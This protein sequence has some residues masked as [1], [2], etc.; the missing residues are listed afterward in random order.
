[1]DSR[2]NALKSLHLDFTGGNKIPFVSGSDKIIYHSLDFVDIVNQLSWDPLCANLRDNIYKTL[3]TSTTQIFSKRY[4]YKEYNH[5]VR[6]AS[7]LLHNCCSV[8]LI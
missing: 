1:M 2:V 7:I 4:H 3:D 8:W 5:G 6:I